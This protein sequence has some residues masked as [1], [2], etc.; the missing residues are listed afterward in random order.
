MGQ[1]IIE[2]RNK[3]EGH[4]AGYRVTGGRES[5]NW[6]CR[7]ISHERAGGHPSVRKCISLK[8]WKRLAK[9]GCSL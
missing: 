5:L 1:R 3:R 9:G 4:Y 7:P 8:G 2:S 6:K